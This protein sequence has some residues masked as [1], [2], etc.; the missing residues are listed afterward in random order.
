MTTTKEE[1]GYSKAYMRNFA[2][3]LGLTYL[4][5]WDGQYWAMKPDVEGLPYHGGVHYTLH[6][7]YL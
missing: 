3:G 1:Q 6:P 2:K 5:K 7:E 4:G